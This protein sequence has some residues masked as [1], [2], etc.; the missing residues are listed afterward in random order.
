MRYENILLCMAIAA[1]VV[2]AFLS[3]CKR[4]NSKNKY[5]NMVVWIW[6]SL[7]LFVW[8][9]T[10]ALVVYLIQRRIEFQYVYEHV[11]INVPMYYR[12]S[13]LWAGQQGSLL[14]WSS[15]LVMGGFV[16]LY[17]GTRYTPKILGT[18]SLLT[19]FVVMLAFLTNGFQKLQT[20]PKDGLGLSISLQDP[21]M[22]IH[23]PLVFIGYTGMAILFSLLFVVKEKVR[24]IQF[25]LRFSE[26]FLGIGIMTGSVW[27]YRCLGWGGFWSWDAIENIALVPWLLICAFLH[28][29]TN[30]SKAMVVL[31]FS[32]AVFG[33]FLTRS[34]I[35]RDTSVHAYTSSNARYAFSLFMLLL[36]ACIAIIIIFGVKYRG[37]L[38]SIQ[39]K[40]TMQLFRLIT[41]CYSFVIFLA[42]ICPIL[43]NRT[44]PNVCY[45]TASIVYLIGMIGLFL[46]YQG[47]FTKRVIT[48]VSV[49]SLILILGVV[50]LFPN[51][52][53]SILLLFW[54]S[55]L[56]FVGYCYF[57][58]GKK[59]KRYLGSHIMLLLFI[60][61]IISAGGFS[62]KYMQPVSQ[63]T[64]EV[65]IQGRSYD[66]E[67]KEE[68]KT[69]L[70]TTALSDYV[71]T[72][73]QKTANNSNGVILFYESK[74][75]ICL[76][77]IGGFGLLGSFL[78]IIIRNGIK[79]YEKIQKQP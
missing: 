5:R 40:G 9:P 66:M 63:G 25:W 22:V 56:P 33:T 6:T 15:I 74:P 36:I 13:A 43:T 60:L 52:K 78:I 27:A 17:Y 46:V 23:P 50:L 30:Y 54:F 24:L 4:I 61:G 28:G 73:V 18:Y 12:I 14:V 41:Y 39:W 79:K 72:D 11:D 21:W 42:T 70:L 3:F 71:I 8:I 48:V 57:L 10:G 26:F 75:L 16:V 53:T 47:W 67:K 49:I 51:I 2:I 69:S 35:L 34:G 44:T 59:N 7:S 58:I 19:A 1:L 76:L 45:N 65:I 20:I 32:L 37:K 31:P 29:K 64:S 77:W 68:G 38:K 62:V 55:L